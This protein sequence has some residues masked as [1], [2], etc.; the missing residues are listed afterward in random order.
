M[1]HL[2]AFRNEFI[3]LAETNLL[4][5][6]VAEIT[7]HRPLPGHRG[8]RLSSTFSLGNLSSCDFETRI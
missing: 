2:T 3:K 1:H 8:S 6:K 4:G 5:K 7:L